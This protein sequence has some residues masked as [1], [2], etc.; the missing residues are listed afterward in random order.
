MNSWLWRISWNI[1]RN[2][3]VWIHL[4]IPA[5]EFMIMKSSYMNLHSWVHVWIQCNEEY[6]EIMAEFLEMN[7]HIKSW[8]HQSYWFSFK[9]V[10]VRENVLLIQSNHHPCL[11]VS[12]LQALRLLCASCGCC[13]VAARWCS[14]NTRCWVLLTAEQGEC[15]GPCK[16][17]MDVTGVKICWACLSARNETLETFKLSLGETIKGI[18]LNDIIQMEQ[19]DLQKDFKQEKAED[20]NMLPVHNSKCCPINDMEI[21]WERFGWREAKGAQSWKKISCWE[22]YC[23]LREILSEKKSPVESENLQLREISK[24]WLKCMIVTDKPE[25]NCSEYKIWKCPSFSVL[26]CWKFEHKQSLKP[27]DLKEIQLYSSNSVVCPTKHFA[28]GQT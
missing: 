21:H 1:C 14:C 10:S 15:G 5:C 19:L 12:S 16:H 26:I 9:F 18:N 27:N 22:K 24:A 17:M 4:W 23:L 13:S 2:S 25:F 20:S 3:Y 6:C 11:A 7:S 28:K 8:I